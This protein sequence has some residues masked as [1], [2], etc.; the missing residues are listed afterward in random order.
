MALVLAL[1]LALLIMRRDGTL[2]EIYD[3]C[4]YKRY[5]LNRRQV[6]VQ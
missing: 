1:V 3:R 5:G 4:Y 6:K 2:A